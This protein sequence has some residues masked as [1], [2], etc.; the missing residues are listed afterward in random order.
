MSVLSCCRY[1]VAIWV[2]LAIAEQHK[3]GPCNS[4]S[5]RQCNLLIH[6]SLV[7]VLK[8]LS[9]YPLRLDDTS[10]H[11][12]SLSFPGTLLYALS[13]PCA[14]CH[15]PEALQLCVNLLASKRVTWVRCSRMDILYAIFVDTFL[16]SFLQKVHV[17]RELRSLFSALFL[18]MDV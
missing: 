10:T 17:S 14:F 9:F 13:S 12:C 15:V 7:F 11:E 6:P 18:L 2:C 8:C 5:N 3:P 4:R 16:C 1:R